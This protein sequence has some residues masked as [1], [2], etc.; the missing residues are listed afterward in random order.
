MTGRRVAVLAWGV[1]VGIL[2]AGALAQAAGWRINTTAS[3][4]RG[5]WRTVDNSGVVRVGDV[6]TFCPPL[7]APIR[8]ARERGYLG[9]GGCSGNLEPM[10]KPVVALAGDRVAVTP[11]GVSVNGQVVPSSAPL[12]ADSAGQPMPVLAVNEAI[13]PSGLVWVVSS[14]NPRSYDSRYLGPISTDSITAVL[15]PLWTEE[16]R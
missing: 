2:L 13:V 15:H 10:L 16:S 4:P 1:G 12:A 3:L 6:V 14:H 8:L 11:L 9:S 5:L 7:T